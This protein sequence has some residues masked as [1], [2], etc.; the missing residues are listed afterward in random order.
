MDLTDF[1][2]RAKPNTRELTEQKLQSLDKFPRWWFDC[3]S[4]AVIISHHAEWPEFISSASLL[5][6]FNESEKNT[7]TYKTI[8]DRDVVA[9]MAKICPSAKREQGMEGSFRRR[10]YLLPTLEIARSDFEKY[11][12]DGVEW[13]TM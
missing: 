5:R 8:I 7:R 12:G 13:E 2:V 10:G 4:Q 9:F 3:L 11:I 1:N 6:L